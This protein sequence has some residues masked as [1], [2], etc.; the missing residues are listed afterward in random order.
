MFCGKDCLPKIDKIFTDTPIPLFFLY[1]CRPTFV[2]SIAQRMSKE[3]QN[4]QIPFAIVVVVL[5]AAL[6]YPFSGIIGYRSVALIL[7]LVMSVLAM[8]MSLRAVLIA[9]IV[10]ALVWDYFFI[11]PFFTFTIGN[12]EDLLLIIMYFIVAL[13]NGTINYRV[14]QLEQ[15]K[16]QKEER[17][18]ALQLYNTLFNALS[19]ELRTPIATILGA[20]DALQEN[21]A[22]LSESHKRAL[23][24]EIAVG[25]LRLSGQV[26]NLL[27]MSRLEAGTI[28]ARK[29][30]CDVADLI[31][32]ALEKLNREGQY[33]KVDTSIPEDLPLVQL[34]FGLTEQTLQNLLSNAFRHTPAGTRIIISA[35]IFSDLSG[36][37][38]DMPTA[39]GAAKPVRDDRMYRLVIDVMD[40]GPGFPETEI[41]RAFDKF[42]RYENTQADG[43]GLGLFIVRGF[44]EAQGGEVSLSNLMDGGAKFTLE[45]PTIILNQATHHG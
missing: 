29:E 25:A 28:Q 43:T 16:N 4:R 8:R 26:E 45:Y 33:H 14:R 40:N 7:L 12:G 34:D 41:S 11:P 20:A 5:V 10:S 24:G 38:E 18:K 13:L 22:S 36:H 35:N 39:S 15:V 3:N 32:G 17:E 2:L 9:A 1:K 6:C 27:N 23:L 19:H 21:E 42:Y 31:N 30:W 44:T 37:F